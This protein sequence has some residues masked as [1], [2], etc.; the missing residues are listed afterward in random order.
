MRLHLADY[1]HIVVLTGAGVS[2]ASGLR[3]YRGPGGVWQE[4]DVERCGHV[5]ALSTH[6]ESVWQ[7]FGALRTQL[8]DARPNAAHAAL[9]RLQGAVSR[10]Q[11]FLLVTQNI[12]G[13]HQRA[14][15][16]YVGELH[17]SITRTRCSRE[18]CKHPVALDDEPHAGAA[19]RCPSCGSPL[20]PD[21]VLFGEPV[22]AAT[23]WRARRA[24]REVELFLA[25]GTSGL[26]SPA[27]DF[28]RSAHYAGAR[29]VYVNVDPQAMAAH[30]SD[31][32]IGKAEDVLPDLF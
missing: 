18:S 20:R 30:F 31:A 10:T 1:R 25:I 8:R 11:S 2:V 3:P 14:G 21:I 16:R 28:V 22:D 7:L 17:G 29:T 6:P 9:A 13:L 5:D 24:L 23:L 26:V 15:S 19:P 4:H 27:A 32:A 12:D